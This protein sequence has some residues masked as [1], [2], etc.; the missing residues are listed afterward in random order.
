MQASQH[1]T[2]MRVIATLV[3]AAH[4]VDACMRH[5]DLCTTAT[6]SPLFQY[7]YLL[8]QLSPEGFWVRHQRLWRGLRNV[9]TGSSLKLR[10]EQLSDGF[11]EALPRWWP[12]D[13]EVCCRCVLKRLHFAGSS[14]RWNGRHQFSALSSM[15]ISFSID[16]PSRSILQVTFPVAC[17]AA[18]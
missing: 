2:L 17:H 1:V 6:T 7:S 14:T 4:A 18:G 11:Q 12:E 5:Q 10:A 9:L 16:S 15:K 3:C 13:G 8:S